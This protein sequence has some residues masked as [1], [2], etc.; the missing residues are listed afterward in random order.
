MTTTTFFIIFIPILA[1]L[2]LSINLVLA[3]HNPLIWTRKSNSRDK[4]LNY[5]EALKLLIPSNSLKTICGPTN[6]WEM[7]TSQKIYESI[8]G[9]RVSKLVS[10]LISSTSHRSGIGKEQRVNSSWS[11]IN[12]PNLRCT[13]AGFERNRSVKILSN[14]I[15]YTQHKKE[16]VSNFQLRNYSTKRIDSTNLNTLFITG[17]TD[18]TKNKENKDL[19]LWGENLPSSVGNKRLTKIEREMIKLP[20]FQHS[21][22]IGLILSDGW[23]TFGSSTHKNAR[24]GFK[25]SLS[26]SSYVWYVFNELSHYC[27]SYPQ[28]KTGI[29]AGKSYS[30]L[31][32]LTRAM[33]CI[34]ELYSLFYP[35][36][37]KIVPHNIYELL[38]PIAL[39]HLVAGDG[40]WARHGLIICTYSYS[41]K[42]VVRLMNV[43]IIRYRLECILRFHRPTQP[44]IYI[45]QSSM[46]LLVNIISPYLDCSMLYKTNSLHNTPRIS[47]KIEVVDVE[48]NIITVYSSMGEAAKNLNIL[49]IAIVQYFLRNQD[50][51]YK[52]IYKFKKISIN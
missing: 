34:T 46:W 36:G 49:R 30:S 6:Y 37:V 1:I 48:N 11:S 44:R 3:Q 7:V 10:D 18:A 42:D 4:L 47:N 31:H 2:L 22:I 23:L 38:T 19:V 50:K 33:P 15:N 24:L 5:G 41:V 25:Q 35:N 39:A 40:S 12:L 52:G 14:L 26:R 21:V 8:I 28:L 29:R 43:M 17:F 27:S 32:F 20:S 51:P 16:W 45:R 9:Y 13:L